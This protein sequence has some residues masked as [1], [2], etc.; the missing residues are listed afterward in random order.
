[1]LKYPTPLELMGVTAHTVLTRTV[2]YGEA[3]L[4]TKHL[5]ITHMVTG[6]FLFPATFNTSPH[7]LWRI[8]DQHSPPFLTMGIRLHPDL[9][10]SISEQFSYA[11]SSR[12][13]SIVYGVRML[14]PSGLMILLAQSA[15]FDTIN[16]QYVWK[17][18]LSHMHIVTGFIVNIR[19]W[20]LSAFNTH[21]TCVVTVRCFYLQSH[22][23]NIQICLQYI[24]LFTSVWT[25]TSNMR[26]LLKG[27][28]MFVVLRSQSCS[29]KHAVSSWAYLSSQSVGGDG[30]WHVRSQSAQSAGQS[31]RVQYCETGEDQGRLDDT[32]WL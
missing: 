6:N 5:T 18:N 24:C 2:C 4:L 17:L 12:W 9:G 20:I 19:K 21:L 22:T 25:R 31:S 8:S 1:M 29:F 27:S 32:L 7:H 28:V 11:W 13:S 10:L 3:A 30:T 23:V 14:Y 15:V 26:P 16:Y